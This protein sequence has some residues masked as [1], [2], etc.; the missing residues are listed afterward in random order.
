MPLSA[1][2]QRNTVSEGTALGLLMCGR[3]EIPYEKLRVDLA[4]EHAFRNWH[5]RERYPQVGTDLRKGLGGSLAM[6]CAKENT[7]TNFV[8]FWERDRALTICLRDPDWDP[9]NPDDVAFAVSVIDNEVPVA[10]WVS[11]AEDFLNKYD[12]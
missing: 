10:A 12:R 9:N 2:N 11:L 8:F 5:Y 4:F 7:R 3:D 6:T 1:T